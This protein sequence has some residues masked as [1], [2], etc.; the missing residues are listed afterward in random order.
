MAVNWKQWLA[1]MWLQLASALQPA[2]NVLQP[3][4]LCPLE[5][6][7]WVSLPAPASRPQVRGE[8]GRAPH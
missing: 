3:H 6:C 7:L 2:G 5:H 8:E 1:A 4:A